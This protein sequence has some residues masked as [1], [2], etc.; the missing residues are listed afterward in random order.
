MPKRVYVFLIGFAVLFSF[1]S[2]SIVKNVTPVQPGAT[3]D[4][5]YVERNKNVHMDGLHPE[6]MDQL[7][8]LGFQVESYDDAPP[9]NAVYTFVYTANWNWD[10]AMYLTYFQGTLLEKGKVLGRVEY[11]SRRGGANMG[12]FGKTAEKI[13]PLLMD[14]FS[15]VTRPAATA[16]A[17]GQK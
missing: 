17:L 12:K 11:D 1:S 8:K 10:M 6:V 4:K 2:C 15:N 5:I 3:I 7:K 16:P 9:A 13:R 14:L